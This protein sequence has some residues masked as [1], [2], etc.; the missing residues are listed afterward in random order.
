MELL[1]TLSDRFC[2][3]MIGL[4]VGDATGAPYEGL[5]GDVIFR[6]GSCREE[7]RQRSFNDSFRSPHSCVQATR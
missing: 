2:G 1:P 3:C 6:S 7:P 4:A 5:P